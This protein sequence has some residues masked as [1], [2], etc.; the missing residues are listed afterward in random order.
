MDD[1][2]LMISM[3]MISMLMMMMM[4]MMM[5]L[6][7]I[8]NWWYLLD[9]SFTSSSRLQGLRTLNLFIHWCSVWTVTEVFI[10]NHDTQRSNPIL[11]YKNGALYTLANVALADPRLAHSGGYHRTNL[12]VQHP[13]LVYEWLFSCVFVHD[14]DRFVVLLFLER[15]RRVSRSKLPSIW[16]LARTQKVVYNLTMYSVCIYLPLFFV[17]GSVK[18]S[19]FPCASK[20]NMSNFYSIYHVGLCHLL[21]A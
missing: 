12:R 9:V 18:W 15:H 5:I 19:S 20:E 6:M 3:L 16:P 11:T 14:H 1:G 4:M 2:W 10:D 7:V 21:V 17:H 13:R 8:M